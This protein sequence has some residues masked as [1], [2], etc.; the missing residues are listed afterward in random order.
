MAAIQIDDLRRHAIARTLFRPTTLA[1]AVRRLGFLQA[2]PMRAPA[3]AQD[4]ILMHRVRDY[5]AGELE[6]RYPRLRL[7]EDCVVNYGFVPRE[8][9]ALLHPRQARRPWDAKTQAQAAELLAHVRAHGRAHPRE[10]QQ[11]FAHHGRTVGYWGGEQN[12]STQLL[13]GLHYRGQLR[14]LRRGGVEAH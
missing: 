3:R 9:L 4:L 13:D 6:Q 7:E 14:V 11:V 10:V 1:Q 8:L 2:D 5:R 12:A